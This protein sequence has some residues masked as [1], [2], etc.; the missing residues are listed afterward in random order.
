MVS[1]YIIKWWLSSCF[2]WPESGVEVAQVILIVTAPTAKRLH[3]LL[4][5]IAVWVTG[6]ALEA[7]RNLQCSGTMRCMQLRVI[8]WGST[9]N[10][11]LLCFFY[12]HLMVSA[13]FFLFNSA[14]TSHHSGEEKEQV[15][16]GVQCC[17]WAFVFTKAECCLAWCNV[18]PS[19]HE[20]IH[21][22][23]T[24]LTSL[25]YTAP[26]TYHWN[27]MTKLVAKRRE[28]HKSKQHRS[29]TKTSCANR[30]TFWKA[31]F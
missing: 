6:P 17:W 4:R 29:Q 19:F 7:F 25:V 23:S 22:V 31:Q 9:V 3:R 30:K 21:Y 26:I 28:K 14:T 13:F 11:Q 24:S 27:S 1:L 5:F 15:C 2:F 20:N 16:W 12:S 18:Y 8:Q 10:S